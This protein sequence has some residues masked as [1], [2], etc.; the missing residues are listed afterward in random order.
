MDPWH[1]LPNP[2]R[3]ALDEVLRHHDT[4]LE[5]IRFRIGRPV[6][7]YGAGWNQP[8][9][10]ALVPDRVLPAELDRIVSILTDHSVYS[11]TEELRQGYLTLPG[12]HR[13][14]IAGRAVNDGGQVTTVRQV[15]SLNIR[16]ARAV[17]GPGEQLYRRLTAGDRRMGSCLIVS[18]PRGG[19]TTLL[20][21]L[22]RV[23]GDDGRR[24]VVI[25]ERSEIA[26]FGGAGASGFGFDLGYHTDVLD[27]WPK[28]AGIEVALRTL[29]PDV[30]AV[31]E[32]GA[33]ADYTAVWQARYSGVEVIATV[34]AGSLEELTRREDLRALMS[35][36]AFDVVVFLSPQPLAGTITEIL[37]WGDLRPS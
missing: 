23:L 14:G 26:G 34:H 36:G 19:K 9:R 21:D 28:P 32:L 18:P 8:L 4:T 16:V 15:T 13:V 33:A 12:G 30:I 37:W 20:R 11:R 5:E 1:Y 25:D 35:G 7:L 29:G 27:G 17:Q 6:H 22:V 31:D 3:T 24:V 10:H 2:W